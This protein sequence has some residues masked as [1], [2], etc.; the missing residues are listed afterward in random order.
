MTP[1]LSGRRRS[2]PSSGSTTRAEWVTKRPGAGPIEVVVTDAKLRQAL[3]VVRSLGMRGHQVGAVECLSTRGVPTFSSRWCAATA[4][5]EDREG[6]PATMVRQIIDLASASSKEVVV[7]PSHDGT[8]AALDQHRD[9][10]EPHCRLA[11]AR[12]GPLRAANDKRLTLDAARRLG[13]R[14]PEEVTVGS[15][16]EIDAA[17]AAMPMPAVLKPAQ[18]WV[19][20]GTA[21]RRLGVS[22][23]NSPAEA[24]ARL[25]EL[26]DAGAFVL[27]Q[28]WVPGERLAVSFVHADGRFHGEFAQVAQRMLPI[29]GGNSVMRQSVALPEDARS[30]ARRLVTELELEG[31]AEVEFRRD[32]EG[33]PVLM[34]VNPRLSASIECAVRSGID[35]PGLVRDWAT[36]RLPDQT[37]ASYRVGVRVR[38]LSADIKW[39]IDNARHQGAPGSVS[40][41]SAVSSFLREFG[42]RTSYDYFDSRDLRPALTALGADIAWLA[43]LPRSGSDSR[44]AAR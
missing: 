26:I 10:V 29:V 30:D 39:L 14:V 25:R 4:R 34:E 13:I 24:R 8:I 35:Y 41:R 38:W 42:R 31:Y 40:N 28:R 19:A 37:S 22:L 15:A 23:V 21:R 9:Q 32:T 17:V 44:G 7:I 16:D 27:A 3:V 18:S 36:D 1:R 43:G 33:V 11:L 2:R 6:D 20:T 12:S 5:V